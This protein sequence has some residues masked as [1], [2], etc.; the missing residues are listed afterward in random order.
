MR[1][2]TPN[3]VPTL[4]SGY[5]DQH[6]VRV[7]GLSPKT[8][9]VY[10]DSLLLFLQYASREKGTAP[11]RLLFSDLD[12]DTV[13]TFLNYLEEERGNTARSRNLRLSALKSFFGYAAYKNPALLDQVSRVK[14]IAGKRYSKGV[15]AYLTLEEV[16]AVLNAP[17]PNSR[18]GLRDRAMLLITYANGLR[19]SEALRLG[20]GDFWLG[21]NP[22]MTILG[23][24]G[25]KD[26]ME[27]L[28]EHVDV[29][30]AWLDARPQ[31]ASQLVFVN[32][33][34]EPLTR[35][36]FAYLLTRYAGIA[37]RVMPSIARKR[38]TPHVL[39]H[40][41]A[42]AVLKATKDPRKAA[43]H[44]RHVGYKSIETY[45]HANPEEQL[46][47]LTAHAE[48]GIKPGKFRERAPGVLETLRLVRKR[49]L[50]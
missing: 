33:G 27:L 10:A 35:D 21:R 39:R 30:R 4:V 25:T 17:D 9:E 22:N 46:A 42:M 43:R 16:T 40:S 36:G 8:Q 23:K 26:V 13:L 14:A 1:N 15:V 31:T 19:V 34:G 24:G 49:T 38:V 48:L 12:P 44:L 2:R 47:T 50:Y 5:L 3:D 6:L 32:R 37:A 7:R 29:L 45:L 18:F 28:P 41:C 20:I 11:D